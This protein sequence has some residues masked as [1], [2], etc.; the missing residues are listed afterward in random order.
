[1]SEF[2][3]LG[4]LHMPTG[5]LLLCDTVLRDAATGKLSAINTFNSMSL[6]PLPGLAK[7]RG[8]AKIWGL[9][10]GVPVSLHLTVVDRSTGEALFATEPSE[11]PVGDQPDIE[12]PV[13]DVVLDLEVPIDHEGAYEVRLVVGD[14]TAASHPLW[15]LADDD[16]DD[17]DLDDIEPIDEAP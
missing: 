16:E 6:H 1:M 4:P 15:V 17:D 2:A 13:L 14:L 7:L 3:A 10:A 11:L 12:D 5:A 9:R 8:I